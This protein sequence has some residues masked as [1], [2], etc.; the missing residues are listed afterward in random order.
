MATTSTADHAQILQAALTLTAGERA[1]LAE[2]LWQ[3]LD[4]EPAQPLSE[5]IREAW[6]EEALRRL[7]EYRAG[8][9]VA[10]PHDEVMA[11]IRARSKP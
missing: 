11:Q 7:D 10:I 1:E 3:S 6:V 5:D 2:R 9:E 4:D 8:R